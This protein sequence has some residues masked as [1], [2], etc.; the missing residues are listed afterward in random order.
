M[1]G[2]CIQ[3]K[4]YRFLVWSGEIGT[5]STMETKM[6]GTTIVDVNI[7]QKVALK[8]TVTSFLIVKGEDSC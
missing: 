6:E 7:V 1:L 5:V 3:S 2:Y 4:G 8:L